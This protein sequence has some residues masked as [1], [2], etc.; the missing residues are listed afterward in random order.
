MS[1]D[2][3]IKRM[4]SKCESALKICRIKEGKGRKYTS[5]LLR[6][7]DKKKRKQNNMTLDYL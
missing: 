6:H 3:Y 4:E 5:F 1:Y 7:E 2:R